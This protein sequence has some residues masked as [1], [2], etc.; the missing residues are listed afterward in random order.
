MYLP[1]RFL[2]ICSLNVRR[3][4]TAE[5]VARKL[6]HLADSAGI[7]SCAV[8][9]LTGEAIDRAQLLICMDQRHVKHVL[10]LRPERSADVRVWD[11]KDRYD[12]G[13]PALIRLLQSRLR[14]LALVPEAPAP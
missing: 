11:I 12:Y 3:S 6:G 2:F 8:R 13:Q 5:H 14:A 7:E 9:P 1:N 4:A 10:R